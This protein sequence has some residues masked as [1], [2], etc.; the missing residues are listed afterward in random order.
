MLRN[1]TP[2]SSRSFSATF[3]CTNSYLVLP[4]GFAPMSP[5][6]VI[7]TTELRE[8]T[9]FLLRGGPS[10]QQNMENISIPKLEFQTL[11]PLDRY[12]PSTYKFVVG[13]R[14]QISQNASS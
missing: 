14:F 8:S 9:I 7:L 10:R 5:R 4:M 2:P 6:R 3:H 1:V 11:P 12:H 13:F